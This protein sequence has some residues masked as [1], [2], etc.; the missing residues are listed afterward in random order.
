MSVA[1]ALYDQIVAWYT[2]ED[3]DLHEMIT[4]GVYRREILRPP[5]KGATPDAF[6]D[7]GRVKV[8]VVI[9]GRDEQSDPLGP[10]DIQAQLSAMMTFPQVWI[11]SPTTDQGHTAGEEL[12]TEFYNRLQGFTLAGPGG[13]SVGLQVASL[14]GLEDDPDLSGAISG[15]IRLQADGLWLPS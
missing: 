1:N 8:S 14:K 3:D 13:S 4:G 6:D 7:G 11:Y 10:Q 15:F 5:S 2:D 9:P 12:I